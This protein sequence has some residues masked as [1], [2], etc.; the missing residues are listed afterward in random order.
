M[1]AKILTEEQE[2]DAVCEKT[3]AF[4]E[5]AANGS[6]PL[7][8]AAWLTDAAYEATKRLCSQA[9]D[10]LTDG[11]E[12]Q[13]IYYGPI[14]DFQL[15]FTSCPIEPEYE[16]FT[17]GEAMTFPLIALADFKVQW[18]RNKSSVDCNTRQTPVN[19]ISSKYDERDLGKDLDSYK[20]MLATIGEL[21]RKEKKKSGEPGFRPEE[22]NPLFSDILEF[23]NGDDEHPKISLIFGVQLL[24]ETYRSFLWR[25]DTA[26]KTNCRLKAL[27]FAQEVKE[28]VKMPVL[29]SRDPMAHQSFE[30]EEAYVEDYLSEKRF[31][32]YYQAPW[33][34]GCHM[35]EILHNSIDTGLR[36]CNSEGS[37]GAVLHMYNALRQLNSMD[38]VPLLEDLCDV[39]QKQ[40]FLGSRPVTN[41]SSQFRR[42]LGGTIEMDTPTNARQG[43]QTIGLP[44]KLPSANS[45]TRR[46]MPG[47]I[48][49]FYELHN[50]RF[51]TTKNFWTRLY[52]KKPGGALQETQL[53]GILNGFKTFN[54]PLTKMRE[55]A[56]GEFN[57]RLPVARINY[58]AIYTICVQ[59]L[60]EMAVKKLQ[61]DDRPIREASPALGFIFV[62]TLL[63]AIVDHQRDTQMERMLPYLSSLRLAR[64][65]I[66][67]VCAGKNV[68]D[69]LW[70]L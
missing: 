60:K 1:T 9:A 64:Y 63:V 53:D 52:T 48:S 57:G 44:N 22:L 40:I 29:P 46:I 47:E 68:S 62:E 15:V 8:F 43:R 56:L 4:W 67:E 23:L 28:T 10:I 6:L 35:S 34:A 19:Y 17:K 36:L 69:F 32:L 14:N 11:Q 65:A 31:D 59:I 33:T 51:A 58:Y 18:R 39:F 66:S 30:M 7:P 21:V 54:E 38:D 55:V 50:Q 16:E 70:D 2:M 41:F 49:L 45:Q 5:E 20:F 61:E 12:L 3:K 26:T 37:V 42:F 13:D 27:R 24:L 25:T